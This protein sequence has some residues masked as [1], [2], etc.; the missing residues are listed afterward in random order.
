[1]ETREDLYRSTGIVAFSLVL[2]LLACIGGCSGGSGGSSTVT[3]NL[4]IVSPANGAHLT[5]FPV[6]VKIAFT[7]GA[8]PRNLKATL[9][10]KDVTRL[11]RSATETTAEA[12]F[13][14]SRL[15][16]SNRLNV[17]VGSA[18]ASAAFG[19]DFRLA[20]SSSQQMW[21]PVQTGIVQGAGD[22][23]S[24]Y[25]LQVGSQ[26]Y[27]APSLSL[28]L[29]F[30]VVVLDRATLKLEANQ[31]FQVI[32]EPSAAAMIAKVNGELQ[33]Q[34]PA[35]CGEFGCI[36]IIQSLDGLGWTPCQTAY[37]SGCE[38]SPFGMFF[39]S[40]G[41]SGQI[42][43]V[44]AN[45]TNQVLPAMYSLIAALPAGSDSV[46]ANSGHEL[47]ECSASTLGCGTLPNPL[48]G[49]ANVNDPTNAAQTGAFVPGPQGA[50]TFVN[51]SRVVV[52][53]GT[54]TSQTS[55]TITVGA[56]AYQSSTIP[57]TS[58]AFQVVI[59]DRTTLSLTS[60]QTFDFTQLDCPGG[61]CMAQ[62][63]QQ[64]AGEENNLVIISSIGNLWHNPWTEQWAQ[65]GQAI[66]ALGGTYS[67]F[68]EL[69]SAM[70]NPPYQTDDYALIGAAS[71]DTPSGLPTFWA[72]EASSIISRAIEPVGLT[73]PASNIQTILEPDRRE[74]YRPHLSTLT[75]NFLS[76]YSFTF[77][78]TVALQAPV[79]W[80]YPQPNNVG[81]NAAFTYI[82][83]QVCQ[84]QDIR[85]RYQDMDPALIQLYER[86]VEQLSYPA[87]DA[88]F[89]KSDFNTLKSQLVQE[90][91][92]AGIIQGYEQGLLRLVDAQDGAV[93]LILD[94]AYGQLMSSLWPHPSSQQL[95][96]E[97]IFD[98]ISAVETIFKAA[99]YITPAGPVVQVAMGVSSA[100]IGFGLSVAENADGSS[101]LDY[102]AGQALTAKW[103]QLS[104]QAL[105]YLTQSQD[106][107]ANLFGLILSD[108]GR[109]QAFGGAIEN[110]TVVLT[111]EAQNAITANFQ[112]GVM[113]QYLVAMLTG[114]FAVEWDQ[115]YSQG[116]Q[117][118]GSAIASC[119]PSGCYSTDSS[120]L[121][122]L[123]SAPDGDAQSYDIYTITN[124]F[125]TG[126]PVPQQYT[127]NL[128]APYDPFD[129]TKG[130]LFKP[131]FF[132]RT[133]GGHPSP[134][135]SGFYTFIVSGDPFGQCD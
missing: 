16:V 10:G 58:G 71:P 110:G 118:P 106:E 54:N 131:W 81:Q 104:E 82:N 93:A 38:N 116:T 68:V 83:Q 6:V 98:F 130:G 36:L 62:V 91:S 30:Q 48:P 32:D 31:S 74:Y 42:A 125:C 14:P 96:T 17:S 87:N 95:T 40:K 90:L 100:A 39:A 45:G 72:D 101:G 7:N 50:Y 115:N 108:W 79:A 77:L 107:I 13:Y 61:S 65:V 134:N 49:R 12:I 29:G 84:C 86:E 11:F 53:T 120:T 97:I 26:V 60:N 128:F 41:G 3:P 102:G 46:A 80:P 64:A 119:V 112:R 69:S 129:P 85:A 135:D 117:P 105:I 44:T 89:S 121:L 123:P 27:Y 94:S 92:Y 28:P 47:L 133:L 51:P 8:N 1:L 52:T 25:G 15:A 5:T 22:N 127:Q 70:E 73:T 78:D 43:Y 35:L 63:L 59:L 113:S 19:I 103:S 109:L 2:V 88:N 21:V 34:Q 75:Q 111:S 76:Q 37:H 57:A 114:V 66:Q 67:V 9:N 18:T 56:N 23:A 24:D 132:S 55:N 126:G 124:K 4:A 99:S 33:Q 20:D 122:A